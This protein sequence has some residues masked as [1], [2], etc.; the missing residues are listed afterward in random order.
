MPIARSYMCGECSHRMELVLSAE[1]WDAPAPSC[2]AC[3]AREMNQEFRPPAIGGSLRGKAR[4]IAED[5]IAN[6]Y[7]VANIKFD[8]RQGGTPKVR[9][10][11]E[12]ANLPKGAWQAAQQTLQQAIDVGRQHRQHRY[13]DGPQGNGLDVLQ[14]ALNT[15]QQ[16]DLIAASKRRAIKVW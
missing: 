15:G 2:E 14:S 12:T 4:G 1:E 10:K 16:P 6:D 8:N 7:N 3:D 9:Y 13:S 5:I 11:D